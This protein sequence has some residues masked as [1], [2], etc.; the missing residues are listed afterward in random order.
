M[1][2]FVPGMK[3][4]ISGRPITTLS[5]AVV[6][7]AFVA[8]E[9]DPLF[10]FSDAVVHADVFSAH[11]LAPAAQARYEEA[12]VR[13][14]PDQRHCLVCGRIV[15]DPNDY[16]GLGHLVGDRQHLLYRFNYAHFHRSCLIGWDP[17]EELIAE[18]DR[19]N[20][21][22][23]WK[24]EALKRL[25]SALRSTAAEEGPPPSP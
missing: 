1:A 17:L 9:A 12:R 25:I 21:S 11:P 2:T 22:N 8:N 14:A 15:A 13:T 3:C 24:G 18:L 19:L 7:P 23:R 5:E 16:V 6:F 10:V 20:R 4:A